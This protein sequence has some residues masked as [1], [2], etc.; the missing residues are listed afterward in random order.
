MRSL[1]KG[2]LIVGAM[3]VFV[4]SADIEWLEKDYDFGLMKEIAGPRTG[5][6]RFVNLGPDTT[7]INKVRPSCGCT[8]AEYTDDL[9]A[10]GDTATISFTYNPAG[11]PGRFEKTVKVYVG[12]RNELHSI[13]IC[14]TVIGAPASLSQDYPVENGRMRLSSDKLD[15]GKVEHGFSTYEFLKGYNQSADTIHPFAELDSR[16]LS[17][18]MSSESVPPGDIFSISFYFNSRLDGQLGASVVPVAV[19]SDADKSERIDVQ[20]L[21]EVV[22]HAAKLTDEQLSKAPKLYLAETRV[23]L[24]A[25]DKRVKFKFPIENQG[26][27]DLLVQ[28]VYSRSEAV[29]IT[30][31][32]TKLKSGRSAYV[33]G[34]VDLGKIATS[35]YGV[36]VEIITNDPRVPVDQVR[37]SGVKN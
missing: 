8:S 15:M 18:V 2:M 27:E 23:E 13:G 32:P 20:V 36:I 28:R 25:A 31:M 33:E 11:R 5:Y 7:V 9:I 30:K 17:A 24:P 14:G 4:A 29:K 1:R 21:T 26:V 16:V 34:E 35:A 37:L 6:G 19:Y 10:P 12:E 3:A 22:P